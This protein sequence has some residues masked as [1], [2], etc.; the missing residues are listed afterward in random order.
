MKVKYE[1]KEY[2]I[3][4]EYNGDTV[5]IKEDEIMANIDEIKKMT[6]KKMTGKED[7]EKLMTKFKIRRIDDVVNLLPTDFYAITGSQKNM[8]LRKVFKII[9][10]PGTTLSLVYQPLSPPHFAQGSIP[11]VGKASIETHGYA[12]MRSQKTRK[13]K[14]RSR[15]KN[16]RSKKR[17]RKKKKKLKGGAETITYNLRISH[18]TKKPI[19]KPATLQI[20]FTVNYL[21]T[22]HDGIEEYR[23][24]NFKNTRTIH[25]NYKIGD[26]LPLE[27]EYK[28]TKENAGDEI[29]GINHSDFKI[30][31]I[32]KPSCIRG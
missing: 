14:R 18:N 25:E 32:N 26:N 3:E 1:G 28:L 10:D 6:L 17:T 23:E 11:G 15:K 16:R 5:D 4:F 29:E 27:L 22:T 7:V 31:E 21:Y 8:I 2:T 13:K 19:Y 30:K 24:Q 20:D 12:R 9:N